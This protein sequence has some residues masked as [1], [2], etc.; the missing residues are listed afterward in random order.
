MILVK[1]SDSRFKCEGR[2]YWSRERERIGRY[3]KY[4][5]KSDF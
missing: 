5:K 1:L 4:S 2:A 3:L